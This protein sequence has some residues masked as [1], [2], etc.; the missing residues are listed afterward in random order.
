METKEPVTIDSILAYLERAVANREILSAH[1][2]LKYAHMMTVLLGAESSLL[3]K[4]QQEVAQI[5]LSY[6]NAQEKINATEAKIRTEARDE[7][8]KMHEQKAKIDR[9]I[10]MV[11]ISKLQARLADAEYRT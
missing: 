9:V 7:Y 2:W 5:K 8:R 10:E 6:L 3:Y 1:D 4:L 11:R